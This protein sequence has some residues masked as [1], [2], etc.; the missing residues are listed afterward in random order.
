VGLG[1]GLYF[2]VAIVGL[3]LMLGIDPLMSQALGAGEAGRARSMLWQGVW[4]ACAVALPLTLVIVALT[5]ALAPLGI[6]EETARETAAYVHARVPGLLPFLVMVGARSYLSAHSMTV[7]M[8]AGVVIANVV[9][10]PVSYSLVFGDEGLVALDLPALGIP[11]LGVAGAGWTST[12]CTI[13]QAA[14][15]LTAVRFVD[16]R[17]SFS[18]RLDLALVRRAVRVGGPVAGTLLAEVGVFALTG[19]LA[20]LLGSRPLAAHNIALTLASTTFQVPLAIGAAAAVRV[21]HG[22]GRHDVTGTRRAGFVAIVSGGAFMI[23]AGLAFVAAPAALAS[24]ITD[25]LGVIGAAVPL[26][27]VAAAF[28]LVDG[29]QAVGAGAL[30]GAGDTRYAFAANVVGHYTIGLPIALLL[31]WPLGLG[32]PGLWWGLCA[33]LTSVAAAL[34]LRFHRISHEVIERS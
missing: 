33:G 21:G 16:E 28:Q 15:V 6:A 30:R 11:A 31:A 1:N 29:L 24:I 5:A 27:V 14:I 3:G 23:A 4:I 13:L 19:F 20:G 12:M 18:R 34:V 7:P 8:V 17:A 10:L 22:V 2:T 25:D 32:V 26:L 9:N